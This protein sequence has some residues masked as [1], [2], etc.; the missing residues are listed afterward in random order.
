MPT[1]FSRR[2]FFQATAAATLA[3]ALTASSPELARIAMEKVVAAT[4]DPVLR[5]RLQRH[6]NQNR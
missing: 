1:R 3:E 5:E 6:L 4:N 2:N